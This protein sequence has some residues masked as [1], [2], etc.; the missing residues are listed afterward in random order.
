M[1]KPTAD[2]VIKALEKDP[3][4]MSEVR[5]KLDQNTYY[6]AWAVLMV[7]HE[8]GQRD[9]GWSLW[10]TEEEALAHKKK[11][12]GPGAPG[13]YFSYEGPRMYLVDAN[14]KAAIKNSKRGCVASKGKHF[15]ARDTIITLELI[16]VPSSE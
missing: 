16:H 13:Q 3:E 6:H 5:K 1:P 8:W 9:E 11:C 7:E 14:V 10:L 2:Q 15:P 4:L 12:E